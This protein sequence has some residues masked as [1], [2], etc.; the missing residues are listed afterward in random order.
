MCDFH[1][2]GMP[3]CIYNFYPRSLHSQLNKDQYLQSDHLENDAFRKKTEWYV[4]RLFFVYKAIK[5][6]QQL[7]FPF[8]A[9]P[10]TRNAYSVS[11]SS[12][13]ISSSE[14][15]S[16]GESE[17]VVCIHEKW[18]GCFFLSPLR[19]FERTEVR[20]TV[21]QSQVKWEMSTNMK[22]RGT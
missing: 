6:A 22:R 13:L 2:G 5:R 3:R 15:S 10:S 11:S 7:L 14:E 4:F 8:G 12:A 21:T 19:S 20:V 16:E 9:A 17:V 1:S 18:I